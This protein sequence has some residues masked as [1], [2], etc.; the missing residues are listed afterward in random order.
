LV[1]EVVPTRS[2]DP[3]VTDADQVSVPPPL[4]ET[5]MVWLNG[6]P[7]P[8]TAENESEVGFTLIVGVAAGATV[9]LT[10]ISFGVLDAPV[11]A[12]RMLPVKV[13]PLSALESTNT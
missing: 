9:K 5:V 11:A 8:A 7:P 4:L 13:P 6:P 12:I 2:N 3:L 10:G 1:P